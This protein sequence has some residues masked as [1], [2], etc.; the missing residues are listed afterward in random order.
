[1][2]SANIDN[3]LINDTINQ[4]KEIYPDIN[5]DSLDENLL[6]D[7]IFGLFNNSNI[8]NKNNDSN[9]S[10][11]KYNDSNI[12]SKI[13]DK[14]IIEDNY[15]LANEYIPEMLCPTNLIYLNGRINGK[16]IKIMIDTGASSC[17]CYKS[18]VDK[19]GLEYLLDAETTSLISGAHSTKSSLGSLWYFK[20]ELDV[21]NDNWVGIP[22]NAIV[23]DD[24]CEEYFNNNEE[25][26][27]HI[28]IILGMTFLKSYKV[29]IN[30]GNMKLTLN[31]K[32]NIKFK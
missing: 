17:I 29:N 20:I 16:T 11:I 22:I 3:L 31:D 18:V 8:L 30:F 32:I 2:I 12:V 25:K 10:D 6:N 23:I 27:S 28:D 14:K 5:I 1:M 9:N 26:F 15:E 4:F 19:C 7:M 24:T 13:F 21:G